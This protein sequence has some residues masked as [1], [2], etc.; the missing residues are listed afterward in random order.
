MTAEPGAVERLTWLTRTWKRWILVLALLLV[1]ALVGLTSTLGLFSSSSANAGNVVTSGRMTQDNSADNTAIMRVT[2]IV[3]GTVAEGAATIQNVGD[4]PG[5][6]TLWVTDVT[7]DPGPGGGVLSSH[8]RMKVF[9]DDQPVP[10][11][12]GPLADLD[13]E[14]GRWEPG[15]SRS[16]RFEVR[17]PTLGAAIDNTYQRSRATATYEWNAVQTQ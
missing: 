16:Y 10:L 7:D 14:L 15:E 3:P 2:G 11:W 6:F 4:A 8:L 1:A 5:S 17:M 13:L 12:T 9:Q